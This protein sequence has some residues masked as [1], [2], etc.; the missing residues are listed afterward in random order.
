MD[1]LR[2]RLRQDPAYEPLPTDSEDA[3]LNDTDVSFEDPPATSQLLEGAVPT[4]PFSW[5]EYAIFLLLGISMLWAW[6]MFLAA[7]PYFQSRFARRPWLLS[8]FQAFFIS[9]STLTNLVSM[10]VLTR[11]QAGASYPRRI[12][13][14]LALN[15]VIF[16]ALAASTAFP[17]ADP[18]VYFVFVM[19]T[20]GGSAL[21]TG[22][23][24]NGIFAYVAGFAHPSY[25]QAIM[26]GQAVA[27][28]LPPL[29]QII[30]VALVDSR[31]T[32]RAVPG[33]SLGD[34]GDEPAVD[35]HAAM[36]Y[37]LT[38][39]VISVVTLLAFLYLE[40]RTHSYHSATGNNISTPAALVTDEDVD[41]ESSSINTNT[42]SKEIPLR[43]LFNKLFWPA[44]AI[45]LVFAVTMA[46]PIYTPRILSITSPSPATTTTTTTSQPSL[47][48][49][50]SFIPLAFLF[51]NAG[52]LLGR[53]LPTIPV[54]S[55]I[56]RPRL[57]TALAV[58]RLGF[59]G[60]YYL[61]NLD[62]NGAVVSSDLFYL[63][64]VQGGF[65]LTNGFLGTTCFISANLWVEAHEMQA[66]GGFMG[67]ALVLGL[68][69]GSLVTFAIPGA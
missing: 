68:T 22:F 41:P 67:L 30:S 33:L 60:L 15:M 53:L 65:G 34:E 31:K 64:V 59:V 56:H 32:G 5:I 1:H 2:Q 3:A 8:N 58:A 19:V 20:V 23:S 61:C 35:W 13:I 37:F 46:M 66:A 57:I 54:L 10:L 7:A 45:F 12:L 40:S 24:Q 42:D 6:N 55:L 38:A 21:A 48:R 63:V 49:P 36:A 27:G 4:H 14:S 62:G 69:A 25:I 50:G 11:M 39:T 26:A 47:L 44:L 16:A 52:D 17:H 51:W 9:I 28:V 29:A 18:E 43:H